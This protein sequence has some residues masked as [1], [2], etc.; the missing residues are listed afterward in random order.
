M[1]AF[2]GLSQEINRETDRETDRESVRELNRKAIELNG[3]GEFEQA[4]Q[5]LNELLARLEDSN[6]EL[7]LK[8]ITWQTLAKVEMNLGNYDES[9]N[10]A[11][12]SLRHAIT[13]ADSANI[14]DNLNTIGIDHYHLSN[15]DSTTFY[16]ERSLEIKRRISRNPYSLAVSEYN[17]GIVYEDLG[18]P[19]KALE[20]YHA[21][22]RNLLD[23]G[24]E[25]NFLSDVYVGISHIHFYGGEIEKAEFYAEKALNQGLRTYGEDNPSIT[26]VYTSYANILEYQQNYDESIEL[27]EKSLEIRQKTYG[28]GH[29]WTCETYYDLANAYLLNGESSKAEQL[30]KRAIEVGEQNQSRQY[31]SYAKTYLAGLYLEEERNLKEAEDLLLSSLEDKERIFGKQNEVVA[32]NYIRLAKLASIEGNDPAFFDYLDRSLF[33]TNYQKDSIQK[34]IAPFHALETLMLKGSWYE[35]EFEQDANLDGLLQAYELLDEEIALVG[36][37]ERNFSSDRSKINLA[38]EYREVFESGLNL[39]WTLYHATQDPRYLDRAFDLSETNR[40]TTLLSGLQDIRSKINLEIPEDILELEESYRARLERVK[41]DLFYE[42]SAQSPDKEYLSSLYNE[43]ISLTVSLDSLYT[44]MIEQFPQYEAAKYEP[45]RADLSE[46]QDYLDPESQ[47]LAYF[48]GDEYLYSFTITKDTVR[49]LRGNIASRIHDK[50][51]EFKNH[52]TAREPVL[53]DAMELYLYLV[54][55]QYDPSKKKMILIPDNILNYIPFEILTDQNEGHLIEGYEISYSGGARI[56]LELGNRFFDY[57]NKRRWAGFAPFYDEGRRLSSSEDEI[58]LIADRLNGD[59]YLGEEAST[60]RF[61]E[62]NRDYSILHLSMHAEIDNNKPEYSKLIFSDTTLTSSEISLSRTQAKLAVLSACNTGF[63]KL[64]KGEGVMSMARAFHLSGVPSVVMSL[65][66]VPDR[67]TKIIMQYFYDH[68]LEGDSKSLALKKAKLDYLENTRDP[69][70]RHP[71]YW[72]GF[73]INGNTESLD[74]RNN[75]LPHLIGISVLIV[76]LGGALWVVARKKS[77][78]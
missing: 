55:Q 23:S 32:E 10:L 70:L 68:L 48:L 31:L 22:E 47:M 6:A 74:I 27:L 28:E 50:T 30:F 13:T 38:N 46:V 12:R 76:A 17:L 72:A 26:F 4:R 35:K 14:A 75:V 58:R 49:F 9:F 54:Y 67:E 42:K 33:S 39:C 18:N 71:Y 73:V 1:V 61:F 25:Q 8:A 19:A 7:K 29:R 2:Q 40:N 53:E 77:R 59:S 41:M 15:Y 43:R 45:E 63:G 64:E 66:K 65:W 11:R 56:Y 16:Y 34:V 24:A 60:S 36:H 69:V 21:A 44:E 52:L 5:L 20:M 51:I 37:I 62:L 57:R 78:S 3:N